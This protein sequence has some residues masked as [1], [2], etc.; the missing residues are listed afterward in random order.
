[1]PYARRTRR[2]YGRVKRKRVIRK[3]GGFNKRVKRVVNRM[4]ETKFTYVDS[5]SLSVSATGSYVALLA[6]PGVG[7]GDQERVGDKVSIRSLQTTGELVVGDATNIVRVSC[8]KWNV[9]QASA[10]TA[11]S[12]IYADPADFLRS[13]FNEY[14]SEGPSPLFRVV[15]DKRYFLATG[16][17]AHTKLF[18][19][20]LSAKQLIAVAAQNM[21]PGLGVNPWM[22]FLILT[23]DSVGAAHPTIHF[24]S[25]MFFKDM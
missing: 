23:S 22:W 19:W 7:T 10:P 11:L 12:Q 1:M 4:V 25:K 16:T 17:T 15:F 18:R 3:R 20:N 14:N 9:R 8:I 24:L 6:M 5:G 2:R 13:T 21:E